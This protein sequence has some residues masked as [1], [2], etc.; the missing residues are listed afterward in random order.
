[1]FLKRLDVAGFKSFA[2][3]ISVDFVQGM[4]A[5]VGPNGSGKSNITDSIRWVLGEQSARSLRGAKME[6]VIFAGS[7]T[8]KA[9]NVAEVT[10]TLENSEQFLPIDYH[11]VSITRRVFRSGESEFF[12]NNQHCRL[13]DI[14]DL[15]M[16][17]GLGRESFS[18]IG[19]GRV[20]EVL[21]SKSDE[22]RK[23]FEEAAGVLKY[24]LRKKKAE[25][26]LVETQDNLNRVSDILYEIES[27]LEP[28]KIQASM[29]KDY[30]EKK[31]E[32]KNYDIS[33]TVYEIEELHKK[34]EKLKLEHDHHK[35][36][37]RTLSESITKKESHIDEAQKNMNVLEQSL[38]EL[39]TVLLNV[40][41][42][43]EKIQGRKQ[44]LIERKKH[45]SKTQDELEESTEHLEEQVAFLAKSKEEASEL[46]KTY[47]QN[48]HRL[49]K[50]LSEKQALFESY[51]E[52]LDEK[53]ENL[54]SDYFE[55]AQQETA[56][57]NERQFLLKQIEQNSERQNRLKEANKELFSEHQ[58]LEGEHKSLDGEVS[59]A[60]E[61]FD[62]AVNENLTLKRDVEAL[63]EKYRKKESLLYQAYQYVE[64]TK[65]KRSMM[66]DMQDG[67][68][69][70]FQGVKE[71]LKARESA[72]TGIEGAVAE[73]I[74]VPKEVETALETALGGAMQHIVVSAEEQARKAIAY[75][76][77]RG[78][79]RATFLPLSTIKGKSIPHSAIETMQG[80]PSFVGVARDLISYEQKYE[81]I[82]S[83]LLGTVIVTK[84]LRGAN[85]LA[86]LVSHRYRFVTLEGDV[87]NPGGS[88]SGGASKKNSSSLI[89]RKREL[90][91]LVAKLAEM[92][93]KTGLLEA[94]VKEL[95][96][97]LAQ[98]E[99]QS[100]AQGE[101][102]QTLK[103]KY[104]ALNAKMSELLLTEKNTKRRLEMYNSDMTPLFEEQERFKQREAELRESLQASQEDMKHLD[105]EIQLVTEQK[106]S[107]KSSKETVQGELTN[108]KIALAEASERLVY[109][110]EKVERA[111]QDL[112]SSSTALSK[113]KDQLSFLKEQMKEGFT[114]QHD[115]EDTL[116]ARTNDKEETA[117][118]IS[119]RRKQ[120][121]ELQE[122]LETFIAEQK[123][124]KRQQEQMMEA[125]KDEE[126]QINRFDVELDQYL[127]MLRE[128]YMLSF[129]AAK[130]QYPLTL[131]PEE[132]RKK[133]RLI[134][135]ALD[136]LGTVNIG[137]IEEYERVSER[138]TFLSE[139]KEDLVEAKDTLHQLIEEMDTEMKKR[140][141]ETFTSVREH[142]KEVFTKLFGG[143]R[144]DLKLTDQEDLLNTGIDIVAQPPGKKLQNLALLSGGERSLTAI[145]LL[146]AILKVRP[147]PFCVLDEVE[148]A[149]DEANVQRFAKFIKTFSEKTQFIVI[150][151]RKGTMEEADVL[152]GVTMQE[153]GVSKL[154]S[155]K[156]EEEKQ[157][158]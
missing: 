92:E 30:L 125:L 132:T 57:R 29:A 37:S 131:S 133:I 67:Y 129:E 150:T 48:V 63:T 93:E 103:E 107:E 106:N 118:L 98:A 149:L 119:E 88:M 58:K 24:K 134:K 79:G 33:L 117:K 157:Y 7:D 142:F 49:K 104:E 68:T 135:L 35:Q 40:S 17:S 84:D 121:T 60:K 87:V 85:E 77:K 62:Q 99:K 44:V 6:D 120:R 148:A 65:S 130:Q 128:E 70:Y 95:K 1:M 2:D 64:Q 66:E 54:K 94:E 34:W 137:A 59:T 4:T 71:V 101:K 23:I 116:L 102:V 31:A 42:E 156:L 32:L 15:F 81:N 96:T 41:E 109:Q 50:E 97:S 55:K 141:S 147:V 74:T 69:G 52:D 110:R 136:E 127:N 80:S 45:A 27:G 123:E 144:A 83:N 22:R 18:I 114:S 124:L 111:E 3:K 47:E 26:K 56:L 82:V 10:L 140:F 115:L 75:L 126:V 25:L 76:K 100:F 146:F 145:A 122:E 8:R 86:R 43:L 53:L 112:Y 39:Q 19:Q 153:S 155:V 113:Q 46:L 139:Q 38:E 105:E 138:Y 91:D 72:L 108:L 16:D 61:E 36:L 151:H 21:S 152:Y 158:V 20:E 51:S 9:L 154:V 14:I 73:L 78:S 143:G 28:L 12:I 89:V 5:V 90:E 11:E 13:K